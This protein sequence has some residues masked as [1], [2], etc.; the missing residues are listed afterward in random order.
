MLS[1]GRFRGCELRIQIVFFHLL[2]VRGQAT[3]RG[4]RPQME[5]SGRWRKGDLISCPELQPSTSNYVSSSL[6]QEASDRNE[7]LF[8]CFY[9]FSCGW[10]VWKPLFCYSLSSQP[11]P[12]TVLH[13]LKLS[14]QLAKNSF[15]VVNVALH[16]CS[17]GNLSCEADMTCF[18]NVLLFLLFSYH[19]VKGE[20]GI[21]WMCSNN[22]RQ[23]VCY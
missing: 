2:N 16:V 12:W 21:S 14:R 3:A 8:S 19:S 11:E 1:L 9:W 17:A 20:G 23:L 18:T 5:A 22:W 4:P 6:T 15:N 10:T 7:S 13:H